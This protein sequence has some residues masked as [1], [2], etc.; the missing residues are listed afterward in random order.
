MCFF[1]HTTILY[2]PYNGRKNIDF[3]FSYVNNS[4]P[5]SYNI[6]NKYNPCKCIQIK[7]KVYLPAVFVEV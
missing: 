3:K 5:I 7:N 4:E 6:Q 2:R 1:S